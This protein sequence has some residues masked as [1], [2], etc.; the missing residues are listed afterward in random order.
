MDILI[1]PEKTIDRETIDLVT[2]AAFAGQ[3][4]SNQTE[5]RIVNGLRD[6][7]AL[8]VS[9]VA[10]VD[11]RLVGHVG[12]SP[13]TINDENQNWYGLG[14]VSVL[15]AL[16]KRGIGSRLI[17]AG[18]AKIRE[19]GAK[20][21]VLEGNPVYYNRFGFKPCPTLIYADGPAEYFM[22]LTFYDN[23]PEGKVEYHPAFLVSI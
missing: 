7:G 19:I 21:C 2:S 17:E 1:R 22:A 9:L 18:L 8:T 23:V 16:Q 15:P 13:V 4:Y 14:P 12:F 10:E 3:P 5:S 20:G 11:G 6:A